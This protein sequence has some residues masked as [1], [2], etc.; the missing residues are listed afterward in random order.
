MARSVPLKCSFHG[1]SLL[2]AWHRA[3]RGNWLLVRREVRSE[4]FPGSFDV[5]KNAIKGCALDEFL[6][7]DFQ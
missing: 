7:H 5:F 1:Y 4:K 6:S 2:E 3:H